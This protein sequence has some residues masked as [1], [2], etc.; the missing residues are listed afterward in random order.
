MK[1]LV[2]ICALTISAALSFMHDYEPGG[3]DSKWRFRRNVEVSEGGGKTDV[4]DA[5]NAEPDADGG[6]EK[7]Q[8]DLYSQ[9]DAMLSAARNGIAAYEMG[10]LAAQIQRTADSA[11]DSIGG[12]VDAA[13][14]QTAID[15]AASSF[16]GAVAVSALF[17]EP[18][19]YEASK[20]NAALYLLNN[21]SHRA[22]DQ[23]RAGESSQA[24]LAAISMTSQAIQD[25]LTDTVGIVTSSLGSGNSKKVDR[26]S[27][28]TDSV[29]RPR[30]RDVSVTVTWSKRRKRRAAIPLSK[31]AYGW[32]YNPGRRYYPDN[33][34][35]PRPNWKPHF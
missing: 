3:F 29:T 28:E 2:C 9:I 30:T 31:R 1:F 15:E 27:T 10:Q 32:P 12:E 25:I 22:K 18:L 21:L 19:V 4:S 13:K 24:S 20:M 34:W 6:S 7:E 14:V 23:E 35:Y 17:D 16:S 5:D 11:L 26:R 8:P 33:R